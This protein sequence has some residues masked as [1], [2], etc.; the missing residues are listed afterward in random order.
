MLGADGGPAS[1]TA[2][3]HPDLTRNPSAVFGIGE[4]SGLLGK[5]CAKSKG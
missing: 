5:R 1:T 2:A 3:V 4:E